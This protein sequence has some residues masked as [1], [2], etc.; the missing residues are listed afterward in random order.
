[1]LWVHEQLDKGLTDVFNALTW[2]FDHEDPGQGLAANLVAV[3][4]GLVIGLVVVSLALSAID[5]LGM[6]IAHGMRFVRRT[7][8]L[9]RRLL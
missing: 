5:G 8:Q 4:L 9:P 2:I 1:V 7:V 3:P 6:I